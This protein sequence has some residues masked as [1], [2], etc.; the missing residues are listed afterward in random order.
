MVPGNLAP[1]LLPVNILVMNHPE[2]RVTL[3]IV[4]AHFFESRVTSNLTG[5]EQPLVIRRMRDGAPIFIDGTSTLQ[6]HGMCRG[7][8]VYSVKAPDGLGQ[9]LLY[10]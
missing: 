1:N 8:K 9:L 10:R 7:F 4:K 3:K 5:R 2:R 6:F